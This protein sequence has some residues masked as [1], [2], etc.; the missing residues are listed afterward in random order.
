MTRSYLPGA[1]GF[2]A[3]SLISAASAAP[4]L[5]VSSGASSLT[6]DSTNTLTTTGTASVTSHSASATSAVL[7]GGVVDG[8]TFG[9]IACTVNSSTLFLD[10]S[11]QAVA[12]SAGGTLT[13]NW[14]D[15][16]IT[17][18]GTVSGATMSAGGTSTGSASITFKTFVNAALVATL[19]P[20]TSSP[21]S[22]NTIG[23][24]AGTS[25]VTLQEQVVLALGAGSTSSGDFQ[26]LPVV[27]PPT[28]GGCPAT[29]GFWKNADK[30]PFPGTLKF[31]V[32]IGGVAYSEADFY[33]ILGTPPQ[34]GNAVLIMGSQLVAA[35]LNIAAGAQ[36]SSAVD[37]E[38]VAA[39]KLLQVGL[40]G[41]PPGVT[42]PINMTTGFVDSSTELG[43]A[44]TTIGT[45]L[46]GYNG[47]N[48]NTCTEGSGLLLG[49]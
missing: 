1:I 25:P 8:F 10:C 27:T 2:L 3:I 17:V 26:M 6:L 29:K 14:T 30:H 43:T 47:A 13:V 24:A 7:V 21:F 32:T 48:F 40:P 38:I 11:I 23:S 49:P 4:V 34:G 18:S 44:M 9:A 16:G 33:T 41:G 36:H 20:F 28:G 31:P 19:G 5:T 37:A 35:L 22:G 12:T 42:F 45:F 39:E 15:S 46:D